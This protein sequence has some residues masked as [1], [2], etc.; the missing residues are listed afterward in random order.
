MVTPV[1]RSGHRSCQ[2]VEPAPPTKSRRQ[3]AA[4]KKAEKEEK[5]RKKN[6]GLKKIATVE[7]AKA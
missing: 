4:E 5:E 7:N 3:V 2:I 1:H 6:K